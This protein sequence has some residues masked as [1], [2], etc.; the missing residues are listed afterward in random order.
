MDDFNDDGRVASTIRGTACPESW[1]MALFLMQTAI[2]LPVCCLD[3]GIPD[4]SSHGRLR[5]RKANQSFMIKE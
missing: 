4:K 2:N 3:D 5:K 1:N